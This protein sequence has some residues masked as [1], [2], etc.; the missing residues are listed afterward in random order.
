MNA[1][2]LLKPPA[3]NGTIY[4]AELDSLQIRELARA[5]KTPLEAAPKQIFAD[6]PVF[7]QD[8]KIVMTTNYGTTVV[9][10]K[11]SSLLVDAKTKEP[12]CLNMQ[13]Y[14]SQK[15]IATL[16]SLGSS[17]VTI[18]EDTSAGEYTFDNGHRTLVLRKNTRQ[19]QPA[20]LPTVSNTQPFCPPVT[21]FNPKELQRETKK[22]Q[23]VYIYIYADSVDTTKYFF[24]KVAAPNNFSHKFI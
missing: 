21:K 23:T 6:M 8:S 5:V 13:V 24:G 22:H 9:E 2:D 17:N 16:K 12:L 10:I 4:I 18:T 7:I 15:D 14:C 20:Q 19:Y 1:T 3:S 11:L